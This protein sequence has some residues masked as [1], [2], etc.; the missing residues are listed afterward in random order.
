[1]SVWVSLPSTRKIRVSAKTIAEVKKEVEKQ[2]GYLIK[3]Q[4]ISYNGIF[5]GDVIHLKRDL[6]LKNFAV[7][8]MSYSSNREKNNL[9]SKFITST[10]ENSR[11]YTQEDAEIKLFFKKSHPVINTLKSRDPSKFISIRVGG[12]A[13][14]FKHKQEEG[15]EGFFTITIKPKNHFVPGSTGI[16]YV[17]S[18]AV[19][20]AYTATEL[21]STFHGITP[22]NKLQ[23]DAF[24]FFTVTPD[25]RWMGPDT[26][27]AITAE[28]IIEG[29]PSFHICFR[30]DLPSSID[31]IKAKI[32]NHPYSDVDDISDITDLQIVC[33]DTRRVSLTPA[34]I[35]T[36]W[37]MFRLFPVI[38][39][40]VTEAEEGDCE[41]VAT[42]TLDERLERAK[43]KAIEEG[44]MC[45]IEEEG[46]DVVRENIPKRE[47][48]QTTATTTSS[49][50]PKIIRLD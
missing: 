49:S 19:Y 30:R 2:T 27:H 37:N 3:Y 31:T 43:Q 42:L 45:T 8:Q 29:K 48:E 44:R 32:C 12:L 10:L 9:I 34:T 26:P 20:E 22:E 41:V 47:R 16:V 7:L 39:R 17:S 40:K 28:V 4:S 18:F 50:S 23:G 24:W 11:K 35:R 6:D 14:P 15:P 33:V 36:V 38:K 1:M 5:H 25:S 21:L 13:I 46:E